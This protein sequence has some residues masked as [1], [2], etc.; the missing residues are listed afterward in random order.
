MTTL[1]TLTLLTAFLLLVLLPAWSVSWLYTALACI[2][3]L[4]LGYLLGTISLTML[5]YISIPIMGLMILCGIPKLRRLLISSPL[6]RLTKRRIK[7]LSDTEQV[8]LSTGDNWVETALFR[9][10]LD[11]HALLSIAPATLTESEQAFLAQETTAL[12]NM[13]DD[14]DIVHNRQDLPP[15]VWDYMKN[16]GFFGLV[17]S[18]EYGGKGFS[19]AAHSAIVKKIATK[20]ITAAITVMVPNSLGPGELLSHYGTTAQKQQLLPQLASGTA[21]PCFAL[22]GTYAGSDAT[23]MTDTGTVI[24]QEDG[25]LAIRLTFDKRYITLAPVATLIGLAFQL[26]DPQQYL[27]GHGK[28]GITLCLIPHD[29]P[30]IEIGDRHMPMGVPFM[31]G[32]I[33]GKEVVIPIEWIIGGQEQA[34]AGWKMLLSCLAIGRAISLPAVCDAYNSHSVLITS[35][36]TALREQFHTPLVQFE[37]IRHTLGN[38]VGLTYL[39]HAM[40]TLTLRAVDQNLQ[41]AVASAMAKYHATEMSRIVINH[42]MDIHGGKAIML[43]IHNP[44][45]TVYQALPISITVEGA[46]ILTRNLIIF[47]QG[48]MLAHPTIYKTLLSL[49]DTGPNAL[50][51]FDKA[52]CEHIHYTSR[53]WAKHGIQTITAGKLAPHPGGPLAHY[54]QQVYRMSVLFAALADSVLIHLGGAV[55]K[56]ECISARLG[57]MMSYLYMAT[58]ALH[59]HAEHTKVAGLQPI[60]EWA[61]C[62]SLY[63]TQ[64]ALIELCQ[65][66]P[67]PVLGKLYRIKL[68][69]WGRPY[70]PPSDALTAA[71]AEAITHDQQLRDWFANDTTYGE[72]SDEGTRC[73]VTAYNQL[74]HLQ[75]QLKQLHQLEK[76]GKIEA[77]ARLQDRI[78]AAFAGEYIDANDCHALS[79]F[80][81]TLDSVLAVDQYSPHKSD[82]KK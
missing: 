13:L 73:L 3:I 62:Y 29:H 41:P 25:R 55:K 30:G 19:A 45:A 2:A 56:H 58:A 67:C 14:W 22:T 81:R 24:Q 26:H 69:P 8:A 65:N 53:N 79:S 63:R 17:I 50:T 44:L 1:T 64:E 47:G 75:P 36:Y 77:S 74:Q 59:T 61:V 68:L 46:N 49:H 10:E 72:T 4:A 5:L 80:A 6:F 57:D 51:N 78:D 16:Q 43:G 33:R 52:L 40:R 35:A 23:A 9:G 28:P 7:P 60:T 70:K 15:T 48:A 39:T 71:I 82:L 21:I 11:M 38:M 12:C 76:Q 54:H 66:Y 27:A 20:S 37:G 34:G 42:A 31:N 32:P 18:P